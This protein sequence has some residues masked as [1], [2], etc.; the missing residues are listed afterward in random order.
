M[1][2]RCSFVWGHVI[3]GEDYCKI[4]GFFGI[5]AGASERRRERCK[6]VLSVSNIALIEMGN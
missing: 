4:I 6:E 5:D 2:A 1:L 3:G